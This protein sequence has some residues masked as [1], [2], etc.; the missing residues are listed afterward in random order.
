MATRTVTRD[1]R[2]IEGGRD[3]GDRRVAVIAG[4]GAGY[5]R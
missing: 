5:V 1:A 2:V 4:I 3:P